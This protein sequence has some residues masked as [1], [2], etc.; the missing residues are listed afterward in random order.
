MINFNEEIN[1]YLDIINY[2]TLRNF[3]VI[4]LSDKMR[5]TATV[6]CVSNLIREM[7]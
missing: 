6:D 3:V 4:H 5:R 1:V 2:I 7:R